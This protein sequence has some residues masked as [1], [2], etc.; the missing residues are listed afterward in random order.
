MSKN[1]LKLIFPLLIFFSHN[2]SLHA[3]SDIKFI[4]SQLI[5][6]GKKRAGKLTIINQG[7][8]AGQAKITF[9]RL[10]A[11]EDGSTAFIEND[12]EYNRFPFN[13]DIPS[14]F[15]ISPSRILLEPNKKQTF[16]IFLRKPQDLPS[17][18]YRIHAILQSEDIEEEEIKIGDVDPDKTGLGVSFNINYGIPVFIYHGDT[19]RG[20]QDITDISITS[21][22]KEQVNEN[23]SHILKFSYA[24]ESNMSLGGFFYLYG[25]DKK[26]R[27]KLINR[28]P[29]S[30]FPDYSR[31]QISLRFILK[32]KLD[33]YSQFHIKIK[34][35]TE[36]TTYFEQD[37]YINI[38]ALKYGLLTF[39]T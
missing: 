28:I 26:S 13:H 9:K 20:I 27:Q 38:D 23:Q 7:D 32:D 2:V 21:L 39:K 35:F 14:F 1:L 19:K 12:I 5:F 22:P 15:K 11:K 34:N 6:D 31:G 16:R 33:Q 4:E 10:I 37:T 30:I 17:G 8:A 24:Q 3:R 18:E 25:Y 29:L 36:E